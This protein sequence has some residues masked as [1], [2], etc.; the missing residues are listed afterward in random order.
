MTSVEMEG[1]NR[2][3]TYFSAIE[4]QFSR[5]RGA[6]L[7]LSPAD[8]HLV[9]SW[10]ERNI[11]LPVVSRAIRE[12]LENAAARGRRMPV[13]SLSYCRHEVEAEFSRYLEAMVGSS[14]QEG[15]GEKRPSLRQRLNQKA[16]R[17]GRAAAH[18]PEPARAP[19]DLAITA[20]RAAAQDLKAGGT[21]PARL[22]ERL[23]LHERELMDHLEGC[24]TT[25]EGETL[26]TRCRE[27]L[28]PYRQ[29]M[30]EEVYQRT[31]RHALDTALRRHFKLPRLSLLSD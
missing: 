2:E 19:A 23:A 22:E 25:T 31:L 3:A 20:L 28:A 18:W 9:A 4:E 15:G 12:V 6:P 11:P 27:R 16:D 5:M 29:R 7:V 21:D 1:H 24:L 26:H 17:L 14:P 30:N 13:L 8:W 10:L